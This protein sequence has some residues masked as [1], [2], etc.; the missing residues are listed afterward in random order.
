MKNWTAVTDELPPEGD[1]VETKFDDGFG[2]VHSHA[3][4]SRRGILWFWKGEPLPHQL[5]P[6]HWKPA[7]RFTP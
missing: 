3:F 5:N 1:V 7:E 6:T 4:L 2:N